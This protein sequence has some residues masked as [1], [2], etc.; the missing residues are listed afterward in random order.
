MLVHME[1]VAEHCRKPSRVGLETLHPTTMSSFEMNELS[2][3]KPAQETEEW[4]EETQPT[5]E[6]TVNEA[7]Y[8]WTWSAAAVYD[9]T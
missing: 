5:V 1:P 9:G 7:I 8:P 3:R 2:D 4:P 6:D